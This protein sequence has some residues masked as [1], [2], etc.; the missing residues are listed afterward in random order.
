MVSK[1]GWHEGH[2]LKLVSGGNKCDYELA[3]RI[4]VILKEEFKLHGADLVPVHQK[5]PPDDKHLKSKDRQSL[6]NSRFG[7]NEVRLDCGETTLKSYLDHFEAVYYITHPYNMATGPD[8]ETTISQ[9]TLFGRYLKEN[10]IRIKQLSLVTPIGP[11]DLNHS[12]D[13]RRKEG[14]LEANRLKI[15]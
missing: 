4:L 14:L 12:V 15:Y 13:R 3:D 9:I 11:Y 7:V 10:N 6:V 8:V 5:N 1:E 2:E